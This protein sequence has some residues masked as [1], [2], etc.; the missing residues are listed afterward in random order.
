MANTERLNRMHFDTSEK[1]FEGIAFALRTLNQSIKTSKQH[2]TTLSMGNDPDESDYKTDP[3][4]DPT[5]FLSSKEIHKWHQLSQSQKNRYIAEGIKASEKSS[6]SR[7]WL[8]N[9][10][11]LGEEI[12]R[13]TAS[14]YTKHLHYVQELSAVNTYGS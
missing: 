8:S 3:I 11:N 13:Q 9:N 14:L 5:R 7:S 12:E 2:L 1:N 4:V 10:E 6:K